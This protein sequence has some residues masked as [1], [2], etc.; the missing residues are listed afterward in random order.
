MHMRIMVEIIDNDINVETDVQIIHFVF[1][2][3]E[4][5]CLTF[6][7]LEMQNIYQLKEELGDYKKNCMDN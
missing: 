4:I 1:K 3:N 5:K 2:K 7:M 6:L